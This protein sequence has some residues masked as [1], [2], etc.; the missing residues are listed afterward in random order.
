[1]DK[2]ILLVV[3]VAILAIVVSMTLTLQTFDT[4]FNTVTTNQKI[5]L[6]INAPS[7]S[8]DLSQIQDIYSQAA[9]TGIGRSNVY[10]FW[11]MIEP[12]KEKF[13][14]RQS[15][16]LMSLN[17]NN[18][19]NVTLYFSLINGKTL[20][21]FP[22][23]IGK[24]S[25]ISVNHDQVVNT[26]DAIL[27]RYHIID[28]VIIAGE[29]DEHF[30]Y[31]E[32]NIPVYEELFDNIYTKLKQKHPDIQIG[33]AYSLHGVINKNLGHVVADLGSLGDFIGFTYFPIDVLND[34]T[35][36]PAEAKQDLEYALSLVTNK[37]I[38]FF[39]LSWSTSNFVNGSED[40]QHEFIEKTFEFY[41]ENESDIEFMTWY[42][43][44]DKPGDSCA[45]SLLQQQQFD[46]ENVAIGGDG[47][48]LGSS[49]YVI[50]RLGNYICSSGLIN[51]DGTP[52]SSWNEFKQ[53]IT[54]LDSSSST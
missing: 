34:I 14:W 23:W 20:G 33:N 54:D 44:Y 15:D 25:L 45:S 8:T 28:T 31:N 35:K 48:G 41:S 29:T 18:N 21:P 49:Q 17:K 26:L 46:K 36:T 12:E 1:M 38:A 30:R 39:E 50:E 9:T 16:I 11:N 10:M 6:V 5:G 24:P 40:D 47:S 52:K 42:R 3:G 51:A 7:A 22:D 53:Q 37:K 19:L 2:K 32:Q 27:T 4:A 43:Q 13:D